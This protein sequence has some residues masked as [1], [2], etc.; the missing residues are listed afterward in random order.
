MLDCASKAAI[1]LYSDSANEMSGASYV[2]IT[3]FTRVGIHLYQASGVNFDN[4]E[5]Y[6][7]S[8]GAYKG[9]YLQNMALDNLFYRITV[10]VNGPLAVGIEVYH[11]KCTM[12]GIH[13]ETCSIGID[14]KEEG[15]VSLF[16]IDAGS[17]NADVPVLIRTYGNTHSSAMG[18]TRNTSPVAIRDVYN[19]I[20]ITDSYVP[21]WSGKQIVAGTIR[22]TGDLVGFYNRTPVPRPTVSGPTGGNV[23]LQSLLRALSSLGL[24]KDSTS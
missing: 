19:G 2:L 10:G 8:T 24:I 4:L 15:V 23:A 12:I 17:I 6:P 1:A 22:H 18:V 7:Q 9:I 20:D 14:L 21:F 11:T 13:I 3:N 16:G 5:V